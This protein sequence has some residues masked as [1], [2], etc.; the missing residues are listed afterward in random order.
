MPRIV[1]IESEL[2]KTAIATRHVARVT[3][4][5]D[6]P[7]C[8]E[9]LWSSGKVETFKYSEDEQAEELRASLVRGMGEGLDRRK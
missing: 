6:A 4:N 5:K 7:K 9:V 3:V 1:D 8:V 2:I